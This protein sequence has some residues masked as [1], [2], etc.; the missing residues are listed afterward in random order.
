MLFMNVTKTLYEECCSWILRKFQ[1]LRKPY[2]K[3]FVHECY[4]NLTYKQI[5]IIEKDCNDWKFSSNIQADCDD[6]KGL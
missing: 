2:M 3:N 1:I 4:E 5:V 6:R